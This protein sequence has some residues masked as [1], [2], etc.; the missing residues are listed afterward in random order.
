MENTNPTKPDMKKILTVVVLGLFLMGAI[1]SIQAAAFPAIQENGTTVGEG[2]FAILP[3]VRSL[4]VGGVTF[5]IVPRYGP[6]QNS[7][8]FLPFASN[9]VATLKTV[10]TITDAHPMQRVTPED[11]MTWADGSGGT[12]WWWLVAIADQGGTV[13]LANI[14][15]TLSSSEPGNI[16]G[17]TVT[18]G[19]ANVGYSALSPGI[20]A[21][22]S[23]VNSGPASEQVSRVIVGVGSK[24]FTVT[25]A[26]D[27][28]GVR[29]WVNQFPNW[30]TTCVVTAQ[31]SSAS[32]SLSKG[33]P[34]LKAMQVAGRFLVVAEDNGDPLSY[35][36]QSSPVLGSSAVWSFAGTI[37]SRQTNDL[38]VINNERNLFIRY[39]STPPTQ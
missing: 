38:G 39:S 23:E 29:N 34:G 18:F 1:S 3:S 10:G 6:P 27:A 17:K 21:N 28:Q 5:L 33:P 36:L 14:T 20:R 8:L 11:L 9:V 31:G 26:S 35:G 12:I 32:F 13:S 24:S 16:L 25:S 30:R 15:A 19:G 7:V 37:K 4:S 2:S 22:G